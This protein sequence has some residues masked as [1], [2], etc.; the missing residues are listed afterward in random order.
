MCVSS[1]AADDRCTG[2]QADFNEAVTAVGE[3]TS[4]LWLLFDTFERIQVRCFLLRLLS[5][6]ASILTAPS[7]RSRMQS[8]RTA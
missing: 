7:P 6:W 3:Y 8:L 2:M 4:N 5:R 1:L